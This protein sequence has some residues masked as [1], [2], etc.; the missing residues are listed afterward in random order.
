[1][2]KL[3]LSFI[4]LFL[5]ACASA[6]D[7]T[8]GGIYYNISSSSFP[9]SC[10]MTY[11]SGNKY[12]GNF[13]IPSTVTYNN[14][15]Y[16]VTSI[17]SDAFGDCA[18]LT[19][20]ALPSSVI[21]VHEKAFYGCA[22]LSSFLV[23][24]ENPVFSC[25]DGVLFNKDQ[26]MLMRYPQGR[27]GS[28][29]IPS[30][31]TSVEKGAFLQCL[32]LSS[33]SIPNSV[34]F[35]GH[36]SFCSC[37]G[38]TSLLIP[39]SVETIDVSAFE[40]CIGLNS[41]TLSS[42]IKTIKAEAFKSCSQLSS[43]SI[44]SSVTSIEDQ[45]FAYCDK[46]SSIYT[47]TVT[48]IDLSLASIVFKNVNIPTCILHVPAGAKSA[49]QAANQWQDFLN[50]VDDVSA[51]AFNANASNLMISITNDKAIIS[52]LP[53]GASVTVYNLQGVA[54]Y[55][56]K[57]PQETISVNLPARGSYIVNVGSQCLRIIN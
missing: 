56:Q 44:P 32:G 6:Y 28:Y 54:I 20:L 41:I 26:T 37:D 18:D 23:E 14:V 7:F 34:T 46:L 36:S 19:T 1:M 47:F 51:S 31:V 40:N 22:N 42:G 57:T 50:I 9:Y 55:N 29:S 21:S 52:G 17:G 3:F 5:M 25:V 39:S 15:T 12:A 53:I 33:I 45:A 16:S 49:Y 10:E 11:S 8:S 35:L 2:K 24:S 13:I 4:C 48:P 38:L 43:V 30:T 27:S